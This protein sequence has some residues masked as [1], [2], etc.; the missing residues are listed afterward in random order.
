MLF[1]PENKG[2]H[3]QKLELRNHNN[4][5]SNHVTKKIAKQPAS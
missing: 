5:I 4:L 2:D 1:P 3:L